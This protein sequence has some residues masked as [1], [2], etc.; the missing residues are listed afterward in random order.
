MSDDFFIKLEKDIAENKFQLVVPFVLQYLDVEMKTIEE[1]LTT[2]AV[3][4]T[5][6]NTTAVCMKK[7]IVEKNIF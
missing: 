7:M 3:H 4:E 2:I 6:H 5:L 1:Y